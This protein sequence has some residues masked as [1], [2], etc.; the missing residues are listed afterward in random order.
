MSASYPNPVTPWEQDPGKSRSQ[1]LPDPSSSTG[2]NPWSG[3]IPSASNL[4]TLSC[5]VDREG[6][7]EV[8]WLCLGEGE[9]LKK[10]SGLLHG[11]RRHVMWAKFSFVFPSTSLRPTPF[12][13]S[14]SPN[15]LLSDVIAAPC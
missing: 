4:P 14:L 12:C 11:E 1:E 2:P 7:V 8:W 9:A 15:L 10:L 13:P 3:S 6:E 5:K